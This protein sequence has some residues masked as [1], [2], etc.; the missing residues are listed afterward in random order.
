MAK[1]LGQGLNSI[2]GLTSGN[3]I[4]DVGQAVEGLDLAALR[5]PGEGQVA[6]ALENARR[7]GATRGGASFETGKVIRFLEIDGKRYPTK[8]LS[9]ID[10]YEPSVTL[11][12]LE[13]TEENL[14]SL[15]GNTDVE[16]YDA[17]NEYTLS[18]EVKVADY[19]D[20]IA[21]ITALSNISTLIIIVL[22]NAL[23]VES[24]EFPLEDKNEVVTETRYV[25]HAV[26]TD[27]S[28]SPFHLFYPQVA[29]AS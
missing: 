6:T 15:L 24:I 28:A 18:L 29:A 1:D 12:I 2:S 27:P 9:R 5:A 17:F 11:S 13:Q 26:D 21:I 22:D 7:I 19:K 25:G 4:L 20:N 8:G 16:E 23:S 14:Q 3:L 10:E